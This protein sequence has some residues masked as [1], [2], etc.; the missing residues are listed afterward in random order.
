MEIL[1]QKYG[2]SSLA[3]DRQVVLV[4]RRVA[5][6]HR[7]GASV[8]VVVSARGDTTDDL[9]RAAGLVGVAPDPVETDKLLATGETASAAL[10]A[11]ALRGLGVPAVSLTGPEAGLRA[12]GRPGHG[13][14]ASVAV[15]PVR[16]WLTERH[17]V[18]VAGFQAASDHGPVITLGRG[19]SD[20]SAVALAVAHG[21]DRCEIH[22]DVDGVRRADPRIVTKPARLPEIDAG[23]MAE[24]AF[25]G[26]RVIHTRAVELAAAHGIDITVHNSARL[27]RGSTIIGRRTGMLDPGTIEGRA[28]VAAVTH[29]LAVGQLFVRTS[30]GRLPTAAA[31]FDALAQRQITV[32]SVTWRTR[33]DGELELS[34]CIPESAVVDARAAVNR[35]AGN[36]GAAWVRRSLATVSAVGT[37]LLSRPGLTALAMRAFLETGIDA[38][39]VSA[40]QARITFLVPAEQ[41]HDAVS[42]L[43]RQFGLGRAGRAEPALATA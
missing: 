1:V 28:G 31:I 24:M 43:Y 20:T 13:V 26:A 21:A 8:I 5:R 23:L 11:I 19:G 3:T 9:L 12:V 16:R 39:C 4:A 22:T 27:G 18:V 30:R 38:E 33:P 41:V 35:I 36:G 2:G 32:D 37:G 7:R 25:S 29:Q 42:A 34:C 40:S 6:A 17:V 15:E 10:L 14:V